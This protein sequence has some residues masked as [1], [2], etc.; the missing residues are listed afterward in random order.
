MSKSV[1]SVHHRHPWFCFQAAFS[2]GWFFT[3]WTCFLIVPREESLHS[4]RLHRWGKFPLSLLRRSGNVPSKSHFPNVGLPAGFTSW[5]CTPVAMLVLGHR[6]AIERNDV[7]LHLT[8]SFP[9]SEAAKAGE[10]L[11]GCEG[12]RCLNHSGAEI[13]LGDPS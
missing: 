6:V 12:R 11:I 1:E 2:D 5:Y 8:A 7:P 4:R 3:D 10:M 13:S 9:V